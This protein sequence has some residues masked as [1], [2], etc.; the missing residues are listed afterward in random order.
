[1]QLAHINHS[2]RQLLTKKLV[3]WHIPCLALGLNWLIHLSLV[4]K[5]SILK[6]FSKTAV[7]TSWTR[8]RKTFRPFL[9]LKWKN[10]IVSRPMQS[11]NFSDLNLTMPQSSLIL[12]LCVQVSISPV[13]LSGFDTQRSLM[14]Q[15]NACFSP[16]TSLLLAGFA[17]Y[18]WTCH[19]WKKDCPAVLSSGVLTLQFSGGKERGEFRKEPQELSKVWE[20]LYRET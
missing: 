1:M 9:H 20:T 19:G 11:E 10:R 15:C 5:S 8:K 12:I 13:F 16:F 6:C 2:S 3:T 7:F 18:L 4:V 17:T 14:L